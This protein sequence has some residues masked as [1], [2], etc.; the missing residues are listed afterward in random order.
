LI[1]TKGKAKEVE[2]LQEASIHEARLTLRHFERL[3][4]PCSSRQIAQQVLDKFLL[5]RGKDVRKERLNK[6]S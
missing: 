4:G 2:G 1:Q 6:A 3:V 5:E